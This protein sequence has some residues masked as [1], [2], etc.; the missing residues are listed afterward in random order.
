MLSGD[1]ERPSSGKHL[2]APCFDSDEGS[3]KQSVRGMQRGPE[4]HCLLHGLL[5]AVA[6]NQCP[7]SRGGYDCLVYEE[8]G[9][10]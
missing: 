3:A 7:L 8:V 10:R 6:S 9:G 4:L 5:G 1:D 2:T